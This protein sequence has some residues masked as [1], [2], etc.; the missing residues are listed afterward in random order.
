MIYAPERFLF[1]HIPRTAGYSLKAVLGSRYGTY[2][3]MLINTLPVRHANPFWC[4]STARDLRPWVMD[5]DGIYKF[6]IM[7][8]PYDLLSSMWRWTLKYEKD[9]YTP[10]TFL[11][12]KPNYP[13]P[14]G[15][16]WEHYCG[17]GV[18]AIRYEHLDQEWPALCTRLGLPELTLPR[19]NAMPAE[20]TWSA[21]CLDYIRDKAAADFE[22]FG[23]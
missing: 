23:Y 8:N 9:K 18:E 11:T 3:S 19:V 12:Q 5:W 21:E 13:I 2:V 10:W 7:R 14:A 16:F 15:G 4:H 1:I 20:H 6:A 17:E 22:R